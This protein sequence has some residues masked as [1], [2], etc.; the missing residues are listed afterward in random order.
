MEEAFEKGAARDI[1]ARDIDG[2]HVL[3]ELG[4]GIVV[5]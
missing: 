1:L 2:N 4:F 5:G 3:Y